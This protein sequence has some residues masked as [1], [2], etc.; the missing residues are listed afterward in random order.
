MAVPAIAFDDSE[1]VLRPRKRKWALVFLVCGAFFG[2]GFLML[3]HPEDA[4]DRFGGYLCIVFFGLCA[5]ASLAQL[6]PGSSFLRLAPD[7]LTFRSMWRTRS[8][9]WSDIERFGVAEVNTV[10]GFTRQRHPMVGFDF[11]ASYPDQDKAVRLRSLNRRLTGFEAALPDNY[12]WSHEA[13]AEHLNML[14]A[15]YLGL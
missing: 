1:Q 2:G 7:G 10:H 13:L 9:R 14:R 11:S 3:A 5:V 8:Y 12:G 15:R 6:V 4:S